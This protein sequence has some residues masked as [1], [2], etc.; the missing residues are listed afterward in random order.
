MELS[1]IQHNPI[2]TPILVA[3]DNPVNQQVMALLLKRLSLQAD[4]VSNGQEAI[5]ALQ[6]RPYRLVLMD[7]EMPQMNGIEATQSIRAST[8]NLNHPVIIALTAHEEDKEFYQKLGFNGLLA[9][10]VQIERL[11]QV[12]DQYLLNIEGSL[13]QT[14]QAAPQTP[15]LA[16]DP[17]VLTRMKYEIGDEAGPI[18][19]SLISTFLE[20]TP[21]LFQDIHQ[22]LS[23]NDICTIHR[24]AHT[25]KSSSANLGVM[26]LSGLCAQLEADL[27]PLIKH[28]STEINL[29]QVTYDIQQKTTLIQAAFGAARQNLIQYQLILDN[30]G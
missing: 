5:N 22:A 9:K 1:N 15:T 16:F 3:E 17:G 28:S 20:Y 18:L 8:A 10:P 25:L 26:Q 11:K 6:T 23:Q 14:G 13:S 12:C 19:S 29:S 2:P 30:N 7:I 24:A 4:W 21:T 27:K